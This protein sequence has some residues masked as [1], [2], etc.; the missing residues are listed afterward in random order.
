MYVE[1]AP[2]LPDNSDL[3]PQTPTPHMSSN[4]GAHVYQ[5]HLLTYKKTTGGQAPWSR[6]WLRTLFLP[7]SPG[8]SDMGQSVRI[9][10][11][12]HPAELAL[13][14]SGGGSV[15]GDSLVGDP[16]RLDCLVNI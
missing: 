6:I 7:S 5:K 16:K 12:A 13:G 10:T 9:T 15:K 3:Q 1:K 8:G 4:F 14:M 11:A 2:S